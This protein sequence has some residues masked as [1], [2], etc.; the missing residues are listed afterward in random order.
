MDISRPAHDASLASSYASFLAA[1]LLMSADS[2][3]D[4]IKAGNA[5]FMAGTPCHP[6]QTMD[7]R[8]ELA[9]GQHPFALVLSCA[10]SRVPP[11]LVFDQGLGDLFVVR[12]A[13]QAVDRAVLGSIQYAVTVLQTPLLVVLGHR[14]CGAVEATFDAVA[15]G[16]APSGTDIDALVAAIRPAVEAAEGGGSEDLL[17]ASVGK[18]VDRVVEQLQAAEVL[19]P[20]VKSG[21]LTV[22]GAV[23]DLASGAV[24]FAEDTNGTER[25]APSWPSRHGGPPGAGSGNAP[26]RMPSP[27]R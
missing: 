7:R 23:Y 21:E 19:G 3:L 17:D 24:D 13:G 18:N 20:A 9:G 26:T 25:R 2:A 4:R 6:G 5:R 12:S 10:D 8:A 15:N 27:R 16:A 14:K 1:D 11:E 22:V